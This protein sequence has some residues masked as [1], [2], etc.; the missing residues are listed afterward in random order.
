M[1]HEEKTR[2]IAEFDGWCKAGMFYG[3]PYWFKGMD[4]NYKKLNELR[5]DR[6]YDWLMPV[7]HKFSGLQLNGLEHAI[8]CQVI[9]TAITNEPIEEFLNE[10]AEA[11]EWYNTTKK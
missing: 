6:S 8:H 9:K 7:W 1:T 4:N 3:E 2:L 11:I 5:Y 10:L